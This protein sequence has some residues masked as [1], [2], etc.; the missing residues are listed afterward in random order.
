MRPLARAV[1]AVDADR[2]TVLDESA[3]YGLEFYLDGAVNRTKSSGLRVELDAARDRLADGATRRELLVGRRGEPVLLRRA[4]A[5]SLSC[6]ES[7]VGP[8]QLWLLR[9]SP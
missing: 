9:A 4:C 8:Y 2:V 6:D 3:L 7:S 5:G 1:R